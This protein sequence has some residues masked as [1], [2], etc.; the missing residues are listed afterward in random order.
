MRLLS[1]PPCRRGM[2]QTIGHDEGQLSEN[3]GKHPNIL[4][5][6]ECRQGVVFQISGCLEQGVI[7]ITNCSAH[8]TAT[9]DDKAGLTL[10]LSVK[11]A[12]YVARID[13]FSSR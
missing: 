5:A 2:P 11:R 8:H 10:A 7:A 9:H 6:G 4:S 12:N 1:R 3:L 13:D